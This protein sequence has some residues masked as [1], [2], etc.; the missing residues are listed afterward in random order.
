M[1]VLWGVLNSLQILT[2]FGLLRINLPAHLFMF[3]EMLM[4]SHFDL[5]PFKD[6]IYELVQTD[7]VTNSYGVNFENFGYESTLALVNYG[8]AFLIIL[9]FLASYLAYLLLSVILKKL[10]LLIRIQNYANR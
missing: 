1:S 10:N 7:S 6:Q 4:V 3:Y 2:F 5:I 9:I 8:D